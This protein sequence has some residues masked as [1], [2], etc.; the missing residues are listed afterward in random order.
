MKLTN[1]KI[2]SQ[3]KIGFGIVLLLVITIGYM[4]WQQTTQMAQEVTMIYKHPVVVRKAIDK[5][6]IDILRMRF[7]LRNF[8]LTADQQEKVLVAHYSDEA[9]KDIDEQFKILTNS[10][11]GPAKDIREVQQ[12]FEKWVIAQE[13]VRVLWKTGKAPDVMTLLKKDGGIGKEREIM[14]NHIQDIEN[15]AIKK[16]KELF[17]NHFELKK[18]LNKQLIVLI[19]SIFLFIILIT[20]FLIK[21][22]ISPLDEISVATQGFKD[23]DMDSRCQ[24]RSTNELGLLSNSFNDL[25]DTIETELLVN[26]NAAKLA[27]IMLSKDDASQF[28]HSV[29]KALMKNTGSQMGA[30]YLLNEA[31]AEF[32]HFESIGVDVEGCKPFSA[33]NFEGEFGAA[34][35]NKK[36]QYITDIPEDTCF[37]FSTVNGK[38][39][40]R[41]IISIPIFSDSE[42]TAVISLA[43]INAFDE[44]SMRILDTVISTLSARMS[45]ILLYQK[46]IAFSKQLEH[47]NEELDAQ[48]GELLS[49]AKELN[50][51]NIELE[52]QKRQ[53]SESNKLKTSFLSNMSHELR[54]PLNS[55]IALSGVLSRRLHG[56][57]SEEEYGY[58]D[59]IERNGKHLL[60]LINDILDLSRFEAGQEEIAVNEFHVNNLIS[61]IIEMIEPQAEQKEIELI[62]TADEKLPVVHNSYGKCQ[63]V[64]QN[65]IANAIKFTEKGSVQITAKTKGDFI[66]IAVID[67]GIGI[68]KKFLPHIFDEFRQVDNSNSRKTGGTG[69]G[70]AIAEKYASLLGGNISA[71]S[72][73]NKGSKFTFEFPINLP[74]DQITPVL[75]DVMKQNKLDISTLN[76]S[77]KTILLVE[78]TEPMIIQMRDILETQGYNIMVARDGG[79]ALELI[80][81]K[82]PDAMILDLMMPNIDGFEVL[83]IIREEEKTSSLPV[84]ILTAKYVN[85]KELSFLKQNGVHQLIQKGSINKDQLLGEIAQML[86]PAESK[87]K[88]QE[89]KPARKVISGEPKILIM[90]DNPDNM[91][92]I[93]ALLPDNCQIIEAENGKIGMK[94]VQKHKPHL[95]LMDIAM[96]EMNGIDTLAEMK[97]HSASKDI[98]VI[99]VSASAM[100]GDRDILMNSGFDAYISKPIDNLKFE[101]TIKEFLI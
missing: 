42:I 100:E 7:E 48:K 90:E 80:A 17:Q 14:L 89:K 97:K 59:V 65:L 31:K 58:L 96:P 20:Y 60:N 81:K 83:K 43:T 64:L 56:T 39:R 101:Q 15:F 74:T 76:T 8:L 95:V 67:T 44:N 3:L 63:H 87:Q 36:I 30:F 66:Q 9:H 72:K 51:Q 37:S 46:L 71:E 11:L 53:L 57:V 27:D 5:L 70:L 34:L 28:C 33:V 18:S 88:P 22:I 78:D 6:R 47:N 92:A 38:F 91:I 73:L 35:A 26:K 94:L 61:D 82:V 29:L 75:H 55:V 45:G 12:A 62:F 98:P 93:K 4:S 52:I 68:D 2:G 10:Y 1:L 86:F 21:N 49:Q 77:D 19:T 84:I 85:K 32:E 99:A 41:G 54:T 23:G 13:G 25:A 40:P 50:A 16:D 69:L 79:E 24:Y